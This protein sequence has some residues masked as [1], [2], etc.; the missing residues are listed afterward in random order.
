MGKTINIVK[1]KKMDIYS[2]FYY[3]LLDLIERTRFS[4]KRF[5]ESSYLKKFN[6]ILKFLNIKV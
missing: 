4:T 5:V 3:T 6:F 1:F 2:F